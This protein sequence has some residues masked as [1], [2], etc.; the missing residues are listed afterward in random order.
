MTRILTIIALLFVTPA[1]AGEEASRKE[2]L[3]MADEFPKCAAIFKVMAI[4]SSSSG[5]GFSAEQDKQLA[6]GAEVAAWFLAGSMG[7]KHAP[8]RAASI[9]ET[10]FTS[11]MALFENNPQAMATSYEPK[12]KACMANLPMQEAIIN[13]A[14]EKTYD[15]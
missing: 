10:E 2:M 1:W 12:Y 9:I 3:Q 8:E 13:M 5:K 15:Q 4:S 7:R 6:I 14:R 11:W